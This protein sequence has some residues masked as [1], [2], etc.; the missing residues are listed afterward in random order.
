MGYV[1]KPGDDV[2]VHLRFPGDRAFRLYGGAPV[3][4]GLP[5]SQIERLDRAGLIVLA[6]DEP[7]P[8]APAAKKPRKPRAPRTTTDTTTTTEG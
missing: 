1:V 8:A 3:P 5:E 4:E 6:D 2:C 7:T